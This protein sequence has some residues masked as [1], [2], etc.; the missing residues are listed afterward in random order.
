MP[1]GLRPGR[2]RSVMFCH[3]SCHGSIRTFRFESRLQR[4]T[5]EYSTQQEANGIKWFLPRQDTGRNS[6]TQWNNYLMGSDGRMPTCFASGRL[7]AKEC[8]EPGRE[9]GRNCEHGAHDQPEGEQISY[10]LGCEHP[11]GL[12][13][14]WDRSPTPWTNRREISQD[15]R[16][17][18]LSGNP[19]LKIPGGIPRF[20]ATR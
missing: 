11:Q 1:G 13:S 10:S 18:A 14:H 7:P 9:N 2:K 20:P 6:K 4:D 12:R 19:R 5:P 17:K 8:A 16:Y 3:G 15:S